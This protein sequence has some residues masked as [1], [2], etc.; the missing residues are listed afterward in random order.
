[1]RNKDHQNWVTFKGENAG[2]SLRPE[3]R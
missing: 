1:M 2:R 3:K